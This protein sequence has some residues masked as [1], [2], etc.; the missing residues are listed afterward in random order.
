M[1]SIIIDDTWIEAEIVRLIKDNTEKKYIFD[2]STNPYTLE[3]ENISQS[4]LKKSDH[5]LFPGTKFN[6][7]FI[8]TKILNDWLYEKK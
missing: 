3:I 8:N 1:R 7:T 5:C 6:E 2:S 4:I